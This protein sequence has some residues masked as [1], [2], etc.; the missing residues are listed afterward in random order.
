MKTHAWL[1]N[2]TSLPDRFYQSVSPTPLDNAFFIHLN[3]HAADLLGLEQ[4]HVAN[5]TSL[6]CF[7]GEQ[8]FPQLQPLA[9][10]YAGHQFGIFT[11]RLG[12]GRV[13]SLGQLNTKS[14]SLFEVQIKG[15][16][17][18]AYS[19]TMDGRYALADAIREYL[20]SIAL[21]ALGI[22][23]T[24]SLCLIGSHTPITNADEY[25]ALLIRVAPSHLRFGHFE[26]YYHHDDIDGL[27]SLFNSTIEQYF[28]ELLGLNMNQRAIRFLEIVIVRT[29]RLIAEWQSI[30]F[31][32]GVMNTDNMLISGETIDLG[33]FGFMENYNPQFSPN[34]AD[35]FNRYQFDQQ[36]EVGRW[37]C[38]ALAQVLT[39]LLTKPIVPS[40]LLRLYRSSYQQHYLAMMRAKLGLQLEQQD[41]IELVTSLEVMLTHTQCDYTEFFSDLALIDASNVESFHVQNLFG[42]ARHRQ[43]LNYWLCRYRSRLAIETVSNQ[44]RYDMMNSI[45]PQ[46][47]LRKKQLDAVIYAAK[48][49]DF[50]KLTALIEQLQNPFESRDQFEENDYNKMALA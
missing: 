24:Q 4:Q 13:V 18:T 36:V 20:A 16:G 41:D 48:K 3:Q 40:G 6:A 21:S 49:G 19:R 9:T 7:N 45:N 14:G 23:C 22:P 38:L 46:F 42:T 35:E 34:P 29:A 10:V 39:P 11:S 12:D 37:N 44:Q 33:T 27:T 1:N 32:H 30:G 50:S 15:A 47:I 26:Y 2:W 8:L 43:Q 31:T 17:L 28:P 25:A 5:E